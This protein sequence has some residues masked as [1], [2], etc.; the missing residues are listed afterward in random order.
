MSIAQVLQWMF[1]AAPG[2]PALRDICDH[3]ASSIA[4]RFTGNKNFDTLERT[5]PGAFTDVILKHAELHPLSKASHAV[6]FLSLSCLQC[7][8]DMLCKLV[9]CGY[10]LWGVWRSWSS[11]PCTMPMEDVLPAHGRKLSDHTSALHSWCRH[12]RHSAVTCGVR[13]LSLSVEPKMHALP[14]VC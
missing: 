8:P 7:A 13:V 9:C 4:T 2:H 6:S 12:S 1:A 5:G 3:I 11:C 14:K 10:L